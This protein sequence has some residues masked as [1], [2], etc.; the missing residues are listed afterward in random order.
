MSNTYLSFTSASTKLERYFSIGN[1]QC[2]RN[3]RMQGMQ[4]HLI[5]NFW[6]QNLDKT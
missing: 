2:R 1:W 5:A 3:W 6:G 4:P